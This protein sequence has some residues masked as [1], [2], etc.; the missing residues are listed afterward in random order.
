M[1]H[2]ASFGSAQTPTEETAISRR[3]FIG[4][5]MA[6]GASAS[7]FGMLRGAAGNA[8]APEARPA[9][10]KRKIRLGVIGNGGRGAWIANLF[11]KHGGYELWAVADYFQNVADKCGDTLGVDK[12]RRFSTLSGYRRLIESGVEAVALETPPY[13]FP[14]HARAAVEAGLHVY[15]A[16]PIAVDVPGCLEVEAAARKATANK[17]C[18]LVDYQIPTDPHNVEVVKRVHAGEIGPV[19]AVY[20]H[21]YAGIFPDPPLT[22]NLESRLQ[23]LT[24]CNDVALGGG[25]HVN[26]CIHAVDAGLWVTGGRP[27]SAMGISRRM[28]ENP[29]GDS[30]DTFSILFEF[31][32][33]LTISH[34]GKHLDN[35]TG[36]NV[37]CQIQG[38]RGHAQTGYGGRAFVKSR[39]SGYDG[40]MENLYEA[41]AVRNIATFYQDVVA[42]DCGN[43]TVRRSVDGALATILGREA[44]A[45]RTRLTMDELLRENKRLEVDLRGLKS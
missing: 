26:A 12:S 43:P 29:H 16:K 38:Q 5:A 41:G 42:E 37:V 24:W 6:A 18:F 11:K 23:H 22:A 27:I 35:L 32:D 10:F 40:Q 7:S 1:T 45:R 4:G 30:H 15:M 31:A 14:E 19:A 2:H 20:T 9:E 25:H 13:C 36:F 34:R 44:A 8:P 39:G 33:G 17:R 28:R 3:R 21:Y